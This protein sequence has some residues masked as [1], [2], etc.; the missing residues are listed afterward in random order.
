MV[1]RKI[2]KLFQPRVFVFVITIG[3]MVLALLG[4]INLI[5]GKT[6]SVNRDQVIVRQAPDTTSEALVEIEAGTEVRMVEESD[7]WARVKVNKQITGWIPKWLLN[8]SDLVNDQDIGAQLLIETS[9]Y[10]EK[11][12]TSEVLTSLATGSYILVEEEAAGWLTVSIQ[13][14]EEQISRTGYIPTRLVNL[15][16][17]TVALTKINENKLADLSRYDA[18]AI[19][20]ARAEDDSVVIVK[21]DNEPVLEGENYYDDV[22]FYAEAGDEFSLV[23]DLATYANADYYLVEAA[24][25]RGYINSDRVQVSTYSIGR[26][27]L[28]VATELSEAVIMLDPGHGGVDTGA[29]SWDGESEEKVATLEIALVIKEQLEAEGATVLLTREADDYLEL[30]ERTEASNVSEVD[31]FISLHFDSSEDSYWSGTTTYY[32]HDSDQLFAESINQ[33]LGIQT[34]ENSGV[35]F[36]N[37]HVLREN[38]RPAIL[39]ELGYM[40]NYYEVDLIFSEEFQTDIATA[41]KTGI[42]NYFVEVSAIQTANLDKSE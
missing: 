2:S 9:V 6:I 3:M 39:L 16:T 25:V 12:E 38:T 4:I 40:S 5:T 28:P 42:E 35:I 33:E 15:V 11:N 41:I 29:L 32:Y 22:L 30:A 26:L 1:K 19:A 21:Q 10:S 27:D 8:T 14:D 24:G 23:G 34:L 18:D 17:E 36:G 37:Y 20:W 31:L 7:G 13:M